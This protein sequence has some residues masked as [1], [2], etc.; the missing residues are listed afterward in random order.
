VD[1]EDADHVAEFAI[2]LHDDWQR[3]G[4]GRLL[5]CSLIDAAQAAGIE[6]LAGT[7][8]ATNTP[9]LRLA[10]RLGFGV[11][12]VPGDWTL[13]RISSALPPASMRACGGL[14][15]AGLVGNA[16]TQPALTSP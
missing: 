3:R 8:L 11:S 12:A 7:T 14:I 10:R 6:R 4:L 15:A 2:V 1:A 5:L 13:K 16:S 9:M